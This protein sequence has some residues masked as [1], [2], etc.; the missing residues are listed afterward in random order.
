MESL[1]SFS[2]IRGWNGRPYGTERTI[3]LSSLY[4][5]ACCTSSRNFRIVYAEKPRQ[6]EKSTQQYKLFFWAIDGSRSRN[7][8]YIQTQHR[9]WRKEWSLFDFTLRNSCATLPLQ[10][11]PKEIRKLYRS[12]ARRV[13]TP[14]ID[15]IRGFKM[16]I[17]RRCHVICKVIID[18]ITKCD[19]P[20]ISWECSRRLERVHSRLEA[21]HHWLSDFFSLDS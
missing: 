3:S 10:V 9:S 11:S 7:V 6:L 2:V 1:S 15:Q 20:A 17:S 14:H 13:I 12:V 4:C 16:Q 5:K 18:E 19:A 8:F 21:I